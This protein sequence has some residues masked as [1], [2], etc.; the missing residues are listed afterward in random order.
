ME[1]NWGMIPRRFWAST[2]RRRADWNGHRISLAFMLAML[3]GAA[4]LYSITNQ[5]AALIG[6]SAFDP[7]TILDDS[8][9][10]VYWMMIPY[11]TLYFYYPM[12][13]WFGIKSESMLRENMIFHQMLIMSCWIVF[14]I[15]MVLPVEIDLRGNMDIPESIFWKSQFDMMHSVDEPWN[16]WP[17]LHIVQSLL[18]VL[19]IRRWFPAK[20]TIQSLLHGLLWLAWISLVLSTMMVKQHFVF[21]VV[22]GLIY[23]S[24][25]WIYWFKPTLDRIGGEQGEKIFSE[26]F[27]SEL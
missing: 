25:C 16:A 11:S 15:F 19:I 4:L 27:D 2:W 26:V 23:G 12:A 18:I 24:A 3:V 14:V 7:K 6:W 10:F 21:D 5:L 9:P 1:I 20:S 13:A 17:S 22:T 8:I